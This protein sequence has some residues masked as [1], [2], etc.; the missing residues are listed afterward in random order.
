MSEFMP[1]SDKFII[2]LEFLNK[3]EG[4]FTLIAHI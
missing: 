2:V 1:N 4:M 3:Q